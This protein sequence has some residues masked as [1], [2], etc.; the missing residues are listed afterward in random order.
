MGRAVASGTSD[1]SD[2]A[3]ALARLAELWRA[4][5]LR[6]GIDLAKNALERWPDEGRF[7]VWLARFLFAAGSLMEAEMAARDALAAHLDDAEKEAAWIILADALIR[8]E[9]GDAA[10]KALRDACLGMPGSVALQGRRGHQALQAKDYAE[11]IDAYQ[12]ACD[13]VPDREALQHGLLAGY[14]QAKRYAVGS[15]AAAR[16]V[17]QFPH[18]AGLTQQYASFLL[19]EGRALE[20][21]EV[22]RAAMGLDPSN[23]AAHWSLVDALWR[24]DRFNAAFKTLE[25]ACDAMPG[26][27]FL[28]RELA[29]LSIPMERRDALIRAYERA[30]ALPEMAPEIWHDLLRALIELERLQEAAATVQRAMLAHPTEP[31]FAT[32]LAEIL[33][34]QGKGLEEVSAALSQALGVEADASEA[35]YRLISGLLGLRRWE[36]AMVLLEELR[37]QEPDQPRLMLRF[38]LALIGQ[39]DFRAAIDLLRE[40]TENHP[41]D[42]EA[43]EALCDAYRQAKD[44][45]NAVAAYR[46]LQSLKA[47]PAMIRRVQ[48]R[49]FGEAGL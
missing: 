19:A 4:Q 37:E 5:N 10:R 15:S 12:A 44:I 45:K 30:I 16:A 2:E 21:A 40:L 47:A 38:G 6:A 34:L 20:A 11:A 7:R 18:S 14:W 43:W 29:R 32:I 9:R 48:T 24:Q 46:R 17:A 26:N 41:E 35:R 33:L 42:L 3:G 31:E 13:L 23:A 39:G 27:V 1:T 36:E 49:L 22:A 28:L 8:Q 25:A